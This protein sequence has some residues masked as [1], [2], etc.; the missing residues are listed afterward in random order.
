MDRRP[1][2]FPT[3]SVSPLLLSIMVLSGCAATEQPSGSTSPPRNAAPGRIETSPAPAVTLALVDDHRVTLDDLRPALLEGAGAIALSEYLLDAR[4]MAA[5]AERGI[6]ITESNIDREQSLMI[7][8]VR[9]S[10]D[11]RG[12]LLQEVRRR[13]A[14]GPIRFAALLRRNAMLR[15]LVQPEVA[16]SE[17]LIRQTHE[18][19][20]G[21]Q[22][23]ARLIVVDSLAQADR[24]ARE[25]QRGSDFAAL[26]MQHS[27]DV[28][29]DRGGLLSPLSRADASY[30]RALR[31][32]LWSLQVG[33]TSG[34]VL[35]DDRYAILR[36]ESISPASGTTLATVR[37]EVTQLAR[38]NQERLL[39]EQRARELV[40]GL[41]VTIFDESLNWA[42]EQ[43][44]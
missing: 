34:P 37:D 8:S 18:L 20:Y 14:L 21:E 9:R 13:Q 44:R 23:T 26:A 22:R 7:D 11:D 32:S 3:R 4:L 6:T 41:D 39:M 12:G 30:P 1:A 27:Q 36:L 25:A 43:T 40:R 2:P 19:L 38:R 33:E 24:L 5:C 31:E 28:S 17:D 35:L 16:V 29:A 15:A 10:S 42:W